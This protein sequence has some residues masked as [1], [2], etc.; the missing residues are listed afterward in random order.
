[1]FFDAKNSGV[2]PLAAQPLELRPV[3]FPS[4]AV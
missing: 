4:A 3:S 2:N 1:M